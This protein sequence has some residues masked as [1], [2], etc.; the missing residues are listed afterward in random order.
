[1]LELMQGGP[2]A[3]ALDACV[4]FVASDCFYLSSFHVLGGQ[5]GDRGCPEGVVCKIRLDPGSL[6]HSF[7]HVF[8]RVM[9]YHLPLEPDT[10]LL[11]VKPCRFCLGPLEN[12]TSGLRCVRYDLM[13]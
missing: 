6:R 11:W 2:F 5:N 10:I 13:V 12:S 4:T 1:M 7:K 3:V 8:K 9:A